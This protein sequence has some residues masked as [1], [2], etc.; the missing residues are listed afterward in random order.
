MR[1][2][3]K[4]LKIASRLAHKPRLLARVLL[5]DPQ[6]AYQQRMSQDYG[7]EKGLP[8]IDILDLV[9]GLDET[10]AP[11]CFMNGSSRTIDQA[12]LKAMARRFD[13]CRYLEIGSLRGESIANISEAAE[14][15]VS[16]SLSDSE[17]LNM[18]L[19]ENWIRNNGFFLAELPRVRRI[20]H[21]STTFDFSQLGKFDMVFVDGN[22]HPEAVMEDTKNAFRVLRDDRSI[23]VWHDYG[24]D[25]ETPW[26]SVLT[27]IMDGAPKD[28]RKNIYHVS[29]TLC[30]IFVRGSFDARIV[31]YPSVPDKT[32]TVRISA[33]RL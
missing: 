2:A 1:K 16:L 21:D 24:A 17:L 32:F 27:G 3:I 9:P 26:W 22:H 12:F 23:I 4:L 7:L 15:C 6:E 33:R 10:I 25:Y 5:D 13:R 14:E 30:A 18:G 29:N 28:L 8:T 11:Y 31:E 19:S 20:G